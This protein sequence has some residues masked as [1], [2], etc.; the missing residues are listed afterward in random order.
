MVLDSLKPESL[1]DLCDQLTRE[2]ALLEREVAQYEEALGSDQ[3]ESCQRQTLERLRHRRL[4][5]ASMLRTRLT[6][7][8]EARYDDDAAQVWKRTLQVA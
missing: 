5:K 7:W 2:L 8:R 6:L 4:Q 3:L 1:P